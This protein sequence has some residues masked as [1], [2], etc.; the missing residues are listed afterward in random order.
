[1]TPGTP[2]NEFREEHYSRLAYA[3]DHYGRGSGK[4]GWMTDRGRT[5][6]VLGPPDNYVERQIGRDT[7]SYANVI[8]WLYESLPGGRLILQFVDR[9]GFGDYVLVHSTK[10]GEL[11]DD[12]WERQ[13]H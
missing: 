5:Y 4:P 2:R 9:T 11:Q 12:S 10:R 13:L 3:N 7:G 8:E 6:I 1:M